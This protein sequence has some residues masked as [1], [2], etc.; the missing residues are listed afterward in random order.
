MKPFRIPGVKPSVE[1]AAV[2][3]RLYE[4]C[5]DGRRFIPK[6]S[7]EYVK[8]VDPNLYDVIINNTSKTSIPAIVML[9]ANNWVRRECEVCKSPVILKGLRLYDYCSN[10]CAIMSSKTQEKTERTCIEKYG[11]RFNYEHDT[12][13]LGTHHLQRNMK[14]LDDVNSHEIMSNL[15]KAPWRD[16]A[17]HFGLSDDS[18]AGTYN[19]MRKYGYPL[20]KQSGTSC[21]EKEVVE[22]VK[23]LTS[24]EVIVNTKSVITPYELDIYI[25][26]KKLAIEFN[27]LYYHSSGN[28]SEDNYNKTRHL[29]KTELCEKL[30]IR[31]LHIFENE[32]VEK[33]D[34]W[35]SVIRSKL[36]MNQRIYARDTVLKDVPLKEAKDFCKQNHLQ[37]HANASRA[38]GLYTSDGKLVIIATFGRARY[39]TNVTSELI[40]MCSLQGVTVVGGASKLLKDEEFISYANRR[41]SNGNVYERLG[42]TKIGSSPPCYWYI[43]KGRVFHRSSF[44]KHKLKD[45]LQ[46]FNPKLTEV[47][48]C[49]DNGLRRFWDC[50]NHIYI[51]VN[52]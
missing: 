22:Y 24:D 28:V 14:N 52:K 26:S 2:I 50:G 30:G 27:G 15:Q 21:L 6:R 11:K 34:I 46:S 41:W 49:Y 47:E 45:R 23:S 33:T 12:Y 37:G 9:A 44:M 20:P 1:N 31:L 35:K 16:I 32:W 17:Q 4:L 40:R 7:L 51:K 48:N 29:H 5:H 42:M 43:S 25:P 36:G 39:N 8:S 3:D 38:K 19:L 10:R 18:H 13:E